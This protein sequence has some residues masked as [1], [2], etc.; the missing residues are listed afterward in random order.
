VRAS[1]RQHPLLQ[2][3]ALCPKFG[4]PNSRCNQ[5]SGTR[6]PIREEMSN[7]TERAR[8]YWAF[9]Q[10]FEPTSLTATSEKKTRKG[11][12]SAVPR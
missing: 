5:T 11:L 1:N 10:A 4:W 2:G 8:P 3:N 6:N 9:T 7:G 12:P